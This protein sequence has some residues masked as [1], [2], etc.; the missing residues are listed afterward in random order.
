CSTDPTLPATQIRALY[1]ARFRLEFVFRDAKQFAGLNT[2]QLRSTVALENHWN[3]AFFAL[4]L[5]RA[6]VLLEEAGR[7][8]RPASR[9]V[10]SYEDIKRRAYN[11]L[12][13]RRILRNLGL[14]ARFHELE[15]HPT[16]PLE[17]GVK[18]A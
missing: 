12:F 4:S 2:C 7:L 8:Q 9:M 16:R 3:A 10:F 11:Q 17:L 14:E 5:G 1:S 6:E 18:A 15:K 13:A